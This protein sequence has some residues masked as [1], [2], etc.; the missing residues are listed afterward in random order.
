MYA[1]EM[2]LGREKKTASKRLRE[3]IQ[4]VSLTLL[5]GIEVRVDL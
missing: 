4:T 1:I 3:N 5:Q 2:S